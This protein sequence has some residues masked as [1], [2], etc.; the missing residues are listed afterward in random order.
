V[1][2]RAPGKT[3]PLFFTLYT[4]QL[5]GKADGD[6]TTER[7]SSVDIDVETTEVVEAQLDAFIE[8][9]AKAGEERKL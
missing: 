1:K 2:F 4:K 7:S 3:A 5:F 9:R 8:K 6:E